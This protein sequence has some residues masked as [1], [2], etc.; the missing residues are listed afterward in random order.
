MTSSKA[1]SSFKLKAIQTQLNH[2]RLVK[3]PVVE[4]LVGISHIGASEQGNT[5]SPEGEKTSHYETSCFLVYQYFYSNQLKQPFHRKL[6][7]PSGSEKQYA[8]FTLTSSHSPASPFAC[9]LHYV[10]T[11]TTLRCKNVCSPIGKRRHGLYQST[12][13]KNVCF[14]FPDTPSLIRVKGKA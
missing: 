4:R 14:L 2:I 11:C 13:Q 6:R 5:L 1:A 10:Q 12:P 3:S 8:P 7:S 9:L